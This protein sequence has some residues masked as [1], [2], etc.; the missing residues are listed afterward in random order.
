MTPQ[1]WQRVEELYHSALERPAALRSG[2]LIEACGDDS[3]LRHQIESLLA[4]SGTE[5]DTDAILD[6]PAWENAPCLPEE[7]PAKLETRPNVDLARLGCGGAPAK[8][9]RRKPTPGITGPE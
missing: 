1:R 6:R 2:F 8:R 7:A 5:S 9:L 3:E 4:N